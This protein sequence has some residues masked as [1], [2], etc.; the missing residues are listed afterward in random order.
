MVNMNDEPTS[1][2]IE[3]KSAEIKEKPATRGE[4]GILFLVMA[5]VIL[6]DQMS[7]FIVESRLEL[8]ST[9]API[10][11]LAPI[12]RVTHVSNTGAAF[13]LFPSGSLLFMLVAIVVSV[14]IIFYNSRLPGDHQLYRV[15]LGLQLGG[16]LGNLID[17][18]RLEHV[19]D[20][21]DFGP[22][23]VFNIA[24]ASVVAG[25]FL[26]GYLILK[27]QRQE[28]SKEMVDM[29]EKENPQQSMSEAAEDHNMLWND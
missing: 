19:T 6:A 5:F 9:W 26:L 1:Y 29:S 28:K 12:F 13:G 8:N 3:P 25:A 27:E 4:K 21:L 7:K 15:A 20:F 2:E 18:L 22:W 24:D 23:P 14:V 10:S 16:A 11:V 17:R